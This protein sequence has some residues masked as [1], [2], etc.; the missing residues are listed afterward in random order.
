[1]TPK[2]NF[3][4]NFRKDSVVYIYIQKVDSN[5]LYGLARLNKKPSKKETPIAFERPSTLK[6]TSYTESFETITR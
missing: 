5:K 2:K 6:T 4:I 3:K 1:M